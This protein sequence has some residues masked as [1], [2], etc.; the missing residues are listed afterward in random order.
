MSSAWAARA[1]LHAEV[2]AAAT[3]LDVEPRFE[4]A[5]VLVERAAQIRESQVVRR[6]EIEFARGALVVF[7]ALG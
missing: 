6:L 2:A 5:Q 3:D 1:P 4:Q 7:V